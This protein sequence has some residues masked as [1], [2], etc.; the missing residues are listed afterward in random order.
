MAADLVSRRIAVICAGASDVA[1]RAAMSATRTIPIVFT[2]ASDPVRAGFVASL[3][4]PEGNLTGIWMNSRTR[5]RNPDPIGS[6]QLSKRWTAVSAAG[7]EDA[8][9]VVMFGM[10]WSPV[11]RFNTG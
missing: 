8:S 1:I 5:S 6:N 9:F 2:T 10:S 4:Q 7:C 3:G 11:R